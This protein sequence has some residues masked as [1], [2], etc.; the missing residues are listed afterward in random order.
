MDDP[1]ER[2]QEKHES[3]TLEIKSPCA[4]HNNALNSTDPLKG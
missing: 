3:V 1:P 2:K 4:S